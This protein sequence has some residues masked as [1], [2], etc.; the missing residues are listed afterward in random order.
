VGGGFEVDDG[1]GTK[2]RLG[3]SAAARQE[4]AVG[5]V[6]R[7]AAWLLEEQTNL[8][9]EAIRYVYSHDQGQ[10]YLSAIIWGPGDVF[11]ADVLYESRGDGVTSFREGFRV[12]TAQRVREIR[13]RAF[14][15]VRRAYVLHYDERFSVS[16]LAG[17][18][19]TGLEGAGA[20][21]AL[22]FDYASP[23][24]PAVT[25][26]PG[27][28]TWRLNVLGTTLVDLDGDGAAEL[29]QLADG[30]HSYRSNQNGT[31][32]AAQSFPGTT[33][34]IATLQLHDIDGD[35]RAD[36]LHDTG[37]GWGVWKSNGRRWISQTA[38]LPNGTWPG[39]AGL[40][41]KQPDD[42]RFADINGDGLVDAIRWD[43]D[44][45]KIHRATPTGFL[46]PVEVGRIA[47][48]VLPS[49]VGRFQDVSGDGLDDY[50][51][52]QIERF[53]IYRGR[54]DGT[55]E[56]AMAVPY[57]FQVDRPNPEDV[58]L[59]DL[60]RDGL[61]DLVRV[62]LGNVRWYRGRADG[63]FAT[64]AIQVDN[65]EPLS[66][67][68]VVAIADLNGN[69]SQD[70]V[71]S[72]R[73]GMWSMDIAGP[74]S[75]GILVRARNGLGMDTSFA[76]QSS[77]ALSVAARQA[78]DPWLHEVPIAMPVPGQKTTALGP[79]ETV[80]VVQ[81]TVRDGYWDPV[82]RRFAGFLGTIVTTWGAT[83]AETSSVQTRYHSGAWPN[84]VLRGQV[85]TQQVRDG[86]GRR[87]SLTLNTWTTR[88][89]AGLPDV[90]LLR[91]ASLDETRTRHEDTTPIRETRVVFEHDEL[92]RVR[93]TVNHGRLDLDHDGS[94]REVRYGDDQEAWVRDQVC[95]E[96]ILE[97]SGA[98]V[99]HVQHLFGDETQTH[100]VCAI[101]KGWLRETR[102]YL[103][104]ESRFVTQSAT[105]YDARG[106][107]VT[108]VDGG[109]SR[110]IN[111]DTE[112]LRP[113]RE[114]VSLDEGELVWTLTW[115][116]ALGV[117]TSLS[118]PDGHT[119]TASHDSLGRLTGLAVDDAIPH[120]VIQYDWSEPSPK[121]VVWDFDGAAE[122]LTPWP[123]S[124]IANGGWRQSVE[125]SNGR[126]EVRYRAVRLAQ[127]QW[128]I[129]DYK[130]RD[131]NSRVIF[132]GRPVYSNQLDHTGRP[133][134]MVGD[135]LKYDPLGRVLEQALPTGTKRLFAYTAFERTKQEASLAP[136]RSVFDGQG[137]AV[138]TERLLPD[139]TSETL[140]ARYDAAGRLVEIA[141]QGRQ[142]VH[143]YEYDTLGRLVHAHDPDIGVRDLVYDDGNRLIGATNGAGQTIS[144][145]Y[146]AAGRL[147]EERGSDGAMFVY[148]YDVAQTDEP[149]HNVVG[150]L[151]WVEEPTGYVAF[152]YDALGRIGRSIR[153][154]EAVRLDQSASI[155]PS[156]LVLGY[157]YDD[158][159][160]I[161][162]A[163]DP[164]GRAIGAGPYWT[165]EEQGADGGM[166]RER[167]GN[168]VVQVFERDALGMPS[169]IRV[170]RSDGTRLYEVAI[171]RND[172]LALSAVTDNDG[173]G[174][175]HTASFGYDAVGR[176]TAATVGQGA[177][178]HQFAYTY[179]ALQNMTARQSVGP[180]T[181]AIVAGEH[182]YGE[183][184]SGPRQLT[185]IQPPDGPAVTFGY[186]GAGRLRSQG[187]L[188]LAYDGLDQLVRVQGLAV[189][190]GQVEH[191]YG[192]DRQRV[193]SIAP[194]GTAT[195]WF[196]ENTSERAGVR[197]RVVSV[198]ERAVARVKGAPAA[199]AA[200]LPGSVPASPL[201]GRGGMLGLFGVLGLLLAAATRRR[202]GVRLAA[203]AAATLAIAQLSCI[204]F[205]RGSVRQA[206]VWQTHEILYFHQGISAGP[207]LFTREDESIAAER[208]FE[209]FG[210]PID[211]L[212]ET[213]TGPVVDDVDFD[214]IDHNSLAKRTDP[215]TGWSYHGARWM[216]PETAR[217]LTP[218]P[219][220]KGPAEKQ[221][222]DP[223]ALHPYQYVGQNPVQFWD[224]AG[225]DQADI[226]RL[227]NQPAPCMGCTS[228]ENL[229][230]S[231]EN[232][233]Q[234]PPAELPD[235]RITLDDIQVALDQV[236]MIDQTPLTN[237]LSAGV[238][239]LRWDLE[240]AGLSLGAAVLTVT[241]VGDE[242]IEGAKVRRG[243]KQIDAARSGG[244]ARG[245]GGA[246]EAG[247]LFRAGGSN[248]GNLKVRPGDD[249]L[250]FRDS[251]SNPIDAKN[252]P[253]FKPGDQYIEVDADRLPAGSVVRDGDPPGHVTVRDA[254]PEQIN[255]AIVGKGKL[256]R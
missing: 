13:V 202:T 222:A 197:E 174:L 213:A 45:L 55:F 100:D 102:A 256:P 91:R 247:S 31:F 58:H 121:T 34:S 59:A 217:W 87:L 47:G 228:Y 21:P 226:N 84:R 199:E 254:T 79:G 65:P 201:A 71:W 32:G 113:V 85:L 153:K 210:A 107:P 23:A 41:L 111:Y 1:A 156:G 155:A 105:T 112:G 173:T 49:A 252:S 248:P 233:R 195:Y 22:T 27:V 206:Q 140:D 224:P 42:T 20:W 204:N 25:P 18:D 19:S 4:S 190:S 93:K 133:T 106:N 218:D 36:L 244:A 81:Y 95:E 241:G 125:I 205:D 175:D 227:A 242:I 74:T 172:W 67:D 132:A 158:G 61:T 138:T 162:F 124:W 219:P 163:Y 246:G 24:A 211:S 243:L 86:T 46:A 63:T 98:L 117:A 255:G 114:S 139:G 183:G 184:G 123:G 176:L 161:D 150:R 99:S 223:A 68:V 37:S 89:V 144:Y 101:G 16:R 160:A 146:D 78:G 253:V 166:L 75:A 8:A 92:V 207:T 152:G 209:P 186:D 157:S 196:S 54:G 208:R 232:Q 203:G 191:A 122:D 185:S 235:R 127:N 69:G 188:T 177:G 3:V 50:V 17:V 30:G 180:K 230:W 189:G 193:K 159:F 221:L 119:I 198:G 53:G 250:S 73:S 225:R 64:Q 181:L 154:I 170:E 238:S 6:M 60:D 35:A 108:L 149:T 200:A 10:V 145:R 128:I 229:R 90:P 115:D 39:T 164:A 169:N 216:A 240:G 245:G 129:S 167:Y 44:D 9:G 57:P 120:R 171:D 80:R 130:E 131:P 116:N 97:S 70:V 194:D 33:Q 234:P 147:L 5:G 126:G 43:N 249:G 237:I 2:Y 11:A 62:S 136:V 109:V 143:S 215:A 76:Y 182:R 178:Q 236:S 142:V 28:E 214:R 134:G 51:E 83:P 15:K 148:H 165:L 151:A 26:V 212:V 118:A 38:Q 103:A 231:A 110:T 141:L 7:T 14:G 135:A 94:T 66:V 220:V 88:T 168:G 137:R 29:A 96:K 52:L 187:G 192:H 56:A 239:V 48:A 12:M 104:G 82:E 179:D 72:S 40:A 77:H 251:L